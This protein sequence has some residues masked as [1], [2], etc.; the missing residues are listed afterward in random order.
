MAERD[1]AFRAMQMAHELHREQRRKYTN[2]PYTDHL[3]EVVA[4]AMSCGW[5][6]SQIHPDTL[7]AVAWLHDAIEDQGATF[8]MLRDAF[9]QEVAHGVVLLSDT[10]SGNRAARKAAARV[11]LSNAPGWVQTIK[12]A[13]LISNTA[14]IVERDPSFAVVYLREKR[15]ML[16]VLDKADP[17]LRQRARDILL[18]GD[19]ALK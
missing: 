16:E 6:Q 13:D 5:H 18:A 12:C 4:I 10:E 11:R 17:R 3:A 19:A 15:M 2:T 8:E 14:S 9:G 1:L 7:M